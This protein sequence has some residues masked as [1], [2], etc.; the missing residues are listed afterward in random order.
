MDW[1]QDLDDFNIVAFSPLREVLYI[2]LLQ[3]AQWFFEMFETVIL[4]ESWVRVKE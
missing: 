4:S 2:I 1:S 3:L